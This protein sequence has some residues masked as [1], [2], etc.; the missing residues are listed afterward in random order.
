VSG[1]L[2]A[3][4]ILPIGKESMV[5]NGLG[6]RVEPRDGLDAVVKRKIYAPT[7]K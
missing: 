2:P 4:A 5:S 1:Q 3:L 7:E 6:G